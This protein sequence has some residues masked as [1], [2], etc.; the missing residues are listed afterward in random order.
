MGGGSP[1]SH[2]IIW[3]LTRI[4]CVSYPFDRDISWSQADHC[5]SVRVYPLSVMLPKKNPSSYHVRSWSR[6][7]WSCCTHDLTLSSIAL[8]LCSHALISHTC[9]VRK[10]PFNRS[11]DRGQAK[12][13]CINWVILQ[14]VSLVRN[15]LIYPQSPV[16]ANVSIYRGWE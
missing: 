16:S 2:H 11:T 7:K 15:T 10:L 9:P 12:S 3:P 6:I 13:S 4:M 1:T 8:S 14:D 5:P